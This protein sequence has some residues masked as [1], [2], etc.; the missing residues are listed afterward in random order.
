MEEIKSLRHHARAYWL[1]ALRATVLLL[2]G[3]R[4]FLAIMMADVIV[5]DSSDS[6]VESDLDL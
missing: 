5:I 2:A 6:D 4:A 1:Q 3:L